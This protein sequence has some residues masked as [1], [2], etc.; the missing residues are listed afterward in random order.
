MSNLTAFL[1]QNAVKVE[2]EKYLASKRFIEPMIDV[3]TGEQK[4]DSNKKPMTKPV[5][6]ELCGITGEEDEALRKSCTK[7]KPVPGKRNM[8]APE[9]DYAEY[10][11]KLVVRCTVFPNLNDA[12]LQNSYGVMGAEAAVKKM[13][14]PGEYAD[15]ANK[16]QEI[17]GFDVSLDEAVDEAKNS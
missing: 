4:L 11:A 14:T 10:V 2:N 9:T 15:L 17:N 7:R 5:E 12:D 13:L 3:K 1:A 8:Y 16:V 6:W